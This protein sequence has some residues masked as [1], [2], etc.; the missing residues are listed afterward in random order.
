MEDGARVSVGVR[1]EAGDVVGFSGNTGYTGGPHLHFDVVNILPEETS[2]L[3][4]LR[5]N[6]SWEAVPSIAAAF[7]AQ[8]P[9]PSSPLV[10]RIVYFPNET[11]TWPSLAAELGNEPFVGLA[12]RDPSVTFAQR[13]G[14][15]TSL[16]CVA[17]VLANNRSGPEIFAMGGCEQPTSKPAVLISRES[18]TKLKNLIAESRLLV[19]L[20]AHPAVAHALP[21]RDQLRSLPDAPLSCFYG[22]DLRY[23][24]RTIPVKFVMSDTKKKSIVPQQSRLYPPVLVTPCS[25]CRSNDTVNQGDNRPVSP[26]QPTCPACFD[27]PT[28]D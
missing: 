3:R 7:S 14:E 5:N 26:S 11:E 19:D 28:I 6:D 17:V 13:I 25:S 2:V 1:V 9:P 18:G 20:S 8:L 15:L 10:A 22:Q 12:D 24:T 4:L 27:R 16:G 21:L 23:V